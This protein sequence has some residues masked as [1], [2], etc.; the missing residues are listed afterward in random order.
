MIE[1]PIE[2]EVKRIVWELKQC[3]ASGLDDFSEDFSE[4][5]WETIKC[6]LMEVVKDFHKKRYLDYGSNTTFIALIQKKKELR[7]LGILDQ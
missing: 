5:N 7:G 4:A 1:Q 6:G 2:E 3:K